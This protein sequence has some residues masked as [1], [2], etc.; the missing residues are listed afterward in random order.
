LLLKWMTKS[1]EKWILSFSWDT[2][3]SSV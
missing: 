3:T 1:K 2:E